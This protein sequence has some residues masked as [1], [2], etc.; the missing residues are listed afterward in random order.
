MLPLFLLFVILP[1]SEIMLLINV[2]DRIGGWNTFFI[3][4]VTAFFGAYFVRQQGFALIQQFQGKMARGEAPGSELAQGI[5]L[6]I[7]GVLLI[8]PG[9][10][11]DALGFLF[12][13]PFSRA[14]IAAFIT[15]KLL[16]KQGPNVHFSQANFHQQGFQNDSPFQ[17]RPSQDE[18][19]DTVIDGE[20]TD[21]TEN[22]EKNRLK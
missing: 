13:L 10:I 11:T 2:S 5:L 17:Q 9:F 22:D 12:T 16:S 18:K 7:A 4:L 15:S 19:D 21:K 6:L 14:P 1:I 8:T 3:V 20:Y